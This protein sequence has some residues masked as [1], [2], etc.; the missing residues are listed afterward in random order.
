VLIQ[1]LAVILRTERTPYII[2]L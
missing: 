2:Y 1:R